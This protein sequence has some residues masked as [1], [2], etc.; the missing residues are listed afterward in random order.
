MSEMLRKRLKRIEE[1]EKK[2]NV[3]GVSIT[4]DGD[5]STEEASKVVENLL[6]TL[7][8]MEEGK[9]KFHTPNYELLD[10]LNG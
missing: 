2:H 8:D 10:K 6:N 1:L 4:A 3:L 5:V 7:D 9:I